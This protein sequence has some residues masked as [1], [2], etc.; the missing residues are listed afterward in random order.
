VH[1]KLAKWGIKKRRII[2]LISGSLI[3][4]KNGKKKSLRE[5]TNEKLSK[6]ENSK[7]SH[8]LLPRTLGSYQHLCAS[9]E[10]Q[11][12]KDISGIFR[13]GSTYCFANSSSF[14]V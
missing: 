13:K 11:C 8:S 10:C 12:S 6:S 1:S 2:F 4:V 9:L 7:D 5:K 14:S 3:W